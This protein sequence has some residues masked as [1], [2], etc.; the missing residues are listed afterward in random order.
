[1]IRKWIIRFRDRFFGI[2]KL[3]LK[4]NS[5][6]SYNFRELKAMQILKPYFPGDYIFESEFSLS[7]Q[8]IQHIIND[9]IIYKP[10][11]ILEFG[12]GLSTI[13][14][15]N[16]IEQNSLKIKLISIDDDL[17]W[18]ESLKERCNSVDFFNFSLLYN[19]PFSFEGKGVWYNIPENHFLYELKYDLVIVDAPKGSLSKMSRY[20]F[21]PFVQERLSENGVVYIDDT[22]RVDEQRIA[23]LYSV[24]G[25]AKVNVRKYH[26]YTRFSSDQIYYTSPS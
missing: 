9:I 12:S 24:T 20:G 21:I 18:Q 10:Q 16:F 3:E 15:N 14:L 17:K 6:Q 13:I 26:K 7:F 25:S 2:D 23:D 5:E 8:I 1:M 11:T 22:H 19:H 4:I